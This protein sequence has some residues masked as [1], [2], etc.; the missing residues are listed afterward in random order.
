[1]PTIL[2]GV[3]AAGWGNPVKLDGTRK[4]SYLLLRVFWMLMP[5]FKKF[6][7]FEKFEIFLIF[8]YFLSLKSFGNS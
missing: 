1:M 7:M 5:K 3:F 4:V 2:C 8:R 6:E